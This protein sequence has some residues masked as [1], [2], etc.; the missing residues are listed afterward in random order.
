MR[1][2]RQADI[3]TALPMREAIR[4]MGLAFQAIS[5]HSVHTAE[6]QV[7]QTAC[8]HALMMGA[9]CGGDTAPDGVAGIV[10]K[11]VTVIP[12]NRDRGLPVSS[13]L[14]LLVD[15]E[16]GQP[17]ALLDATALTAW[18]TAAAAG[19]ATDLLSRPDARCGLMVGSGTQAR[20]QLLAMDS[21]RNLKKIHV[22]AQTPDR[23]RILIDKVQPEVSAQLIAVK[24]PAENE[25]AVSEAD[26]ITTATTATTPVFSGAAASPGCHVNGIG[27][28]RPDMR[29][30]DN[31][32]IDRSIVFVESRLTA[33]EEAGELIAGCDSGVT[34]VDQWR[35][36]GEVIAKKARGRENDQQIT[37]YKSVGHSVFDLFAASAIHRRSEA[38]GLGQEWSL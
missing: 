34:A 23:I 31:A 13:G 14:A 6:R 16:N 10:T 2:L 29:E 21:V 28:F 8:G 24:S 25:M 22:M 9:C 3:E 30:L 36:V 18:R 15:H 32:L 4:L 37:F 11:L 20:A 33:R 1:L 35:E 5:A 38:L 27:S 19:F 7:L 17:L 26:L 12:A